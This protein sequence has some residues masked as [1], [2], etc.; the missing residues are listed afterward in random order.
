MAGRSG[1][2]VARVIDDARGSIA[3]PFAL[4]FVAIA[5]IAAL[6]V[7]YSQAVRMKTKMQAA[8][9]AA[10]L[11]GARD[12]TADWS[13]AAA[14]YFEHNVN[15]GNVA[16]A[17]PVFTMDDGGNV[18]GAVGGSMPTSLLQIIGISSIRLSV[19][20]VASVEKLEDKSCLL[21]L[22]Q[23]QDLEDNSIDFNGAPNLAFGQ[24]TVRSNTSL[25]CNGH[26]GGA[27]ASIG[28]GSISNCS[29]PQPGAPVVPDIYA[30]RAANI[31][32]SCS[33]VGAAVTW[34][35]GTVPNS[36]TSLNRGTYI[37]Y[38]VCGDLQL[39][40]SGSL[41]GDAPTIDSVIIVENGDL[42]IADDA[43][44]SAERVSIVLTGDNQYSSS[45][46][47]PNG[48]GKSAT[49]SLSPPTT[50]GNPWRGVSLYQDPILNKGVDHDW[51]PGAT[52]RVDGV[53]Y[54]PNSDV[55][56]SGNGMSNVS[57]CTKF[58]SNSFRTNGAVDISFR[59]SESACM[60][61]GVEQ[62]YEVTPFLSM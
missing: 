24:C 48:T 3:V 57:G 44:I 7:D 61:L 25:K 41:I 6:A 20:A 36:V 31:D 38:H 35:P 62:W 26:D 49:L 50:A 32:A 45:I 4:A 56:M 27:I 43:N 16:L 17:E 52:L 47:F 28:T 51:G 8:L 59:Q 23:D 13:Q 60:S 22:G 42:I 34:V 19:D 39:A 21:A 5:G 55:I 37:E 30:S 29:N 40:G 1:W 11:A 9:D 14:L 53:V 15:G 2:H 46:E 33:G 58:V 10:V 54:L 18:T 12:G